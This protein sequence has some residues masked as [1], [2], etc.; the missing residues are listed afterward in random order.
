M[1]VKIYVKLNL[2]LDSIVKI[3][4]LIRIILIAI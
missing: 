3:K 1:I 2:I 4:S